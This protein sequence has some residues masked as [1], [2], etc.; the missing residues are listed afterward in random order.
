MARGTGQYVPSNA[1]G[2]QG[3][4]KV[5]AFLSPASGLQKIRLFRNMNNDEDTGCQS[6]TEKIKI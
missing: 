3:D 6:F 4:S 5:G 1:L 2:I